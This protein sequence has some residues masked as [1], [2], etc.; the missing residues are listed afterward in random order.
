RFGEGVVLIKVPGALGSGFIVHENGTIVTNAHVVQGE[1][2]VSVT[3]YEKVGTQFEKRTFDKVK[4]LAVNPF[5]DL[6]LLRI[7]PSELE[8]VTLRTVPLGRMEDV[9]V[10]S[11]VFVVGAPQGLE[12]SVTEGI[13][14]IK[15]R[16]ADGKVYIQ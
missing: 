15:N 12:R 14:S 5:I 9:E 1:I 7:D 13:V 4:I 16:A 2:D 8:G 6:A 3:I 10:G 11:Q